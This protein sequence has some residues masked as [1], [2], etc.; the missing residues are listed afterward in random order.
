MTRDELPAETARLVTPRALKGYAEGLGWKRVEGVN[1]SIAVYQNPKSPLRQMIV[2]LDEQFDDYGERTA[3]A[4]RKLAEYEKRPASEILNHLLLPPADLL[5]FREISSAAEA[6]DLPLDHAA[7]LIDGTRRMLL[8]VAHSVVAP[9][10]YHPRMSRGRPPSSSIALPSRSNGTRQLRCDS[11]LPARSPNGH[12]RA[13]PRSVRP[14]GDDAPDAVVARP[15]PRQRNC[16]GRRPHGP[17][18]PSRA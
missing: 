6:G 10:P 9:Q 12:V 13:E 15:V 14:A 7:R 2:P 4:I 18:A 11:C 5:R 1:G 16:R 17:L 3:E 8:S